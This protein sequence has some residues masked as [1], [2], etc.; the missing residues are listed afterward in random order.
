M[1]SNAPDYE[2]IFANAAA[3]LGIDLAAVSPR[4]AFTVRD[5]LKGFL[6]EDREVVDRKGSMRIQNCG[7][8][9]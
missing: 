1:S 8:A 5:L 6:D 2:L 3:E 9:V 4:A 7:L